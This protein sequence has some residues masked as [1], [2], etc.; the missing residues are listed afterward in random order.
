MAGSP[1]WAC[2]AKMGP[3]EKKKPVAVSAVVKCRSAAT[4]KSTSQARTARSLYEAGNGRK[5][6]EHG[7]CSVSSP[8]QAAVAEPRRY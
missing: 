8:Q 3:E 4:K 5:P 6:M 1:F 2:S 7:M